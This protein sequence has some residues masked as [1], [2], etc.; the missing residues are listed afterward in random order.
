MET[1]ERGE[2]ENSEGGKRDLKIAGKIM[3]KILE[4]R[5]KESEQRIW[6]EALKLH[7]SQDYLNSFSLPPFS[8]RWFINDNVTSVT[9]SKCSLHLRHVLRPSNHHPKQLSNSLWPLLLL[10][11][12]TK[13]SYT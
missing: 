4:G 2:E 13:Q 8:E 9:K 11:P 12:G 3:T 5:A 1:V 7:L 6:K 10:C